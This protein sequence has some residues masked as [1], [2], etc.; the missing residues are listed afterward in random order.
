MR[1]FSL[2]LALV[3]FIVF[4]TG[5]AYAFIAIFQCS[6][7]RL[8]WDKTVPEGGQCIDLATVARWMSIPNVVDGLVMLVMPVP[9]VW[10]LAI[11][12]QQK[13]ALTATFFHG[14][15]YALSSLVNLSIGFSAFLDRL[16]TT[17][18]LLVAS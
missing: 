15:M 12:V 16:L 5:V 6:P 2:T 9:V 8:A 1:K 7:V 18:S 14:I 11:E 10:Q 3:A 17:F 13:F 4:T